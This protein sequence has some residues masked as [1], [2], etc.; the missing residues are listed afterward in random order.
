MCKDEVLA[1]L[2]IVDCFDADAGVGAGTG[3]GSCTL[4]DNDVVEDNGI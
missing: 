3:A 4:E 2:L 1:F